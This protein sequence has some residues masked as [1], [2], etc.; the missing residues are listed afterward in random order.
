MAFESYRAGMPRRK[1]DKD[2]LF[3]REGWFYLQHQGK[4]HSLK[5]Q[6]REEA[7]REAALVKRRCADPAHA[8]AHVK[9]LSEACQEFRRYATTGENRRKPPA[10]GTFQMYET[11]FGNLCRVIGLDTPLDQVDA[12]AVDNYIERRRAE[13]IG[14]PPG[15]HKSRRTA[16][17]EDTRKFVDPGT[18]DKELGTLR[19]ILR[20]GLRRGWYHLPIER[21]VPESAGG[22]YEPLTRHLTLEQVPLLLDALMHSRTRNQLKGGYKGVYRSA[23]PGRWEAKLT[24]HGD[25]GTKQQRYLGYFTDPVAAARAYDVGALELLGP[26]ARLNFPLGDGDE[27]DDPAGRAATCAYI[28]AFGADWCAVERAEQHDLGTSE[29]CNLAALIR[30]TKNAQR[31]AEVPLVYPFQPF[32]ELARQYLLKHGKFPKWGKQRCRDLAAACKRA[33][34]PRI[35]P[36]DLRR[37]HGKILSALGVAPHLIGGMLRHSDSRMAERVYARPEREDVG[38]QVAAVTRKAG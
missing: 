4:R 33:G 23:N 12:T 7:R 26:K 3:L 10:A 11:H 28:I 37:T 2:G 35:T 32:A 14:K 31:W 25:T 27:P 18:V 5:T 34:L 8:A 19:Q 24:Y 30:G 36:R 20:L 17:S 13:R 38:R 29:H 22:Q 1:R 16:A 9:S 21:V 6:D 15:T